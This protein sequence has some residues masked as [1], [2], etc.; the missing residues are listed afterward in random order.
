MKHI[1]L[2]FSLLLLSTFLWSQTLSISA[3]NPDGLYVCGSDQTTITIQN[4]NGQP[5]ATNLKVTVTFP[6]GVNYEAGTVTGAT[7]S[8]ISN[9]NAPVFALSDLAG[10][11]SASFTITVTGGCPLV[12]AINSGQTFANTILAN[13]NGGSKQTITSF[14]PI[15]TGLLNISSINPP[16]VNAQKGDVV[17][18]MITMKNTRQG[19]I[20]SLAFSDQHFPGISIDLQGGTNQSNL[21]TLFTAD[22]PGSVFTSIGDNDDLFEFGEELTLVEKVTI[23]DCG[24]PSITDQSLI[25]I[26][27]GC[28]G[29]VCRTD[30]I[31]AQIVILPTTQNP[32][33]SFIPVYGAPVSQCG[34]EP[35]TQEILI[36]N[37]GQLAAT[38]VNIN[39]FT[40]DTG[41]M[42]IDQG[43]FQVNS[44]SGWVPLVAD[45]SHATVLGSCSNDDYS[46]DVAVKVPEVPAGDTVRLRFNTYYCEPA[47]GALAPRMRVEY[48][49]FK[50]CPPNAPVGGIFNFYP[51]TT[52]LKIKASVDYKLEHCLQDD[53]I[54][55]LHYWVKSGRLMHDT[56]YLQVIFD[57]PWG[58]DWMQDCPF[59]LGGQSPLETHIDIDPNT[60]YTTVRMVFDLPILEDSVG[61]DLC[62]RYHCEQDL[63]C[64]S[65]IPNVPPRGMDYTVISPPSDCG[66]CQIKLYA[67]S[68][69]STEPD[70]AFNC[71]ITYCDQFILIVDNS[72]DTSGGGGGG[73][74]GLGGGLLLVDFKSYRTNYGF[75]DNN[76]DRHADNTNIAK[77][78]G[79]RRDRFL[80]GDTLRDELKAVMVSG[81]LSSLSFRVFF[82]SW[83]SDF[84]SLDGDMYEMLLGK[85]LFANYDTTSFAGAHLTIKTAGGQQYD[86]PI[87]LPQIRSDQHLIQVAEPNIRPPQ[88]RDALLNMFHQ[89]DLP[90]SQFP[91]LPPGFALSV[92][93]SLIFTSDFKFEYN[94]KP[95]GSNAPPLINFRNSICDIDKTLSWKLENF[96]TDKDLC[97]FSGYIESI[98]PEAQVINP[99]A[100][101]TELSPFQYNIRIARPNMFPFEVRQL[102]TVTKYGYSL[103]T[104]VDLLDTK[105]NFLRLQD[106]VSLF[107]TTLLNPG[108]GGDSLTLDLSSF[109]ADPLD[110]GYGFELST[111]FDTTCGYNGTQFGRTVLG[112]H[113]ANMCFHNPID[114]TYL[115]GNPNGYASGSPKLELPLVSNIYYLPTDEVDLQFLLHNTSALASNNTWLSIEADGPLAGLQLLELPAQTPV[116]QIGG[117]YQ[118][119]T[120]GSNDIRYFQLKATNLSC[121][122]VTLKIKFGWDCA[123]VFNANGDACGLFVKTIELRPQPPELELVILK[124]PQDIPL[125]EP[126]DYF[127]FEISNANDGSALNVRPTVKLPPGVRIQPGSSQLSYPAGGAYVNLPDPI[128]KIGNVWEFDPDAVSTLLAQDGLISADMAPLNTLRIRF[129]ILAECGAV[130]NAQ[131]IFGA[132]AVQAC[133]ISSNILRKPG[134]PLNIA[135][136]Q[137]S[138]SATPNLQFSNLPAATGCGVEVELTAT[139]A[140]N[141]NAA[142]GDS[143]YVLLPAGTS[144]VANSYIKGNNAPAG[145]PQI[146]GHQIQLPL[147]SNVGAG[148]ILEFKFKI[149]YDD[150]GDCSDKFL[151]LQT[152]E[153]TEAYCSSSNKLCDIYVATGEALLN[154]NAQN[155]ELKLTNFELNTQGGNTTF[156]AVLENAGTTVANNPLVQI[157]HDQNGNGQVDAGE[158]KVFETTLNGTL[159][160]GGVLPFNGALSGVANSALCDLIALIPGAQNC[161]CSDQVFPLGGQQT[162]TQG[163]GLCT[164]QSVNVG[165]D[166]TAGNTY[167]W[168][169]PNGLSCLNCAHA[170]YIPTPDVQP[171]E[172]VTLVLEEKAGDCTIEHKFEIQYGG[173]FG[174]ETPSQAICEGEPV[175]LEATS[176]GSAYQWSGPG[177]TNPNLPTQVVQPS[178]SAVYSVT[179][180]FGGGCTGT[181]TVAVNVNANFEKTLPTVTI[182][183]GETANI[184]GQTTG[185]AGVYRLELQQVNGCDSIITQELKV[186]PTNIQETAYFCQGFSVTVLDSV[187]TAPGSI[188]RTETASS[189][190]LVTTCYTVSAYANPEL[191]EQDSTIIISVNGSTVIETPN[192]FNTYEW[193]PPGDLSCS[194]CP[195]PIATNDTSTT[196]I[197]IVTDNHGCKDT[198]QYRIFVC[199]ENE[200]H[201]PNAFSPNGDSANDVFRVVPHEGAEVIIALRVYDRWGQKLY[202]G[203]G[204]NA[205]WDG[206]IGDKL[207]PSDT[208]VYILEYDCG[209]ERHVESG[210]VTLLR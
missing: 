204:K 114:K 103:P 106:N 102:S 158:P 111:R 178:S 144:Y 179:V 31:E 97:Q 83:M 4:G 47:C 196:F 75:Q 167:T 200:L 94:F 129:R 15:E 113:Y 127:E 165:A 126:S 140:M 35:S 12:A 166:S 163:I 36:V 187:F 79:V 135:G 99:C 56:G 170:I 197:L 150:P 27:W 164:L 152:R 104:S 65:D 138:Y 21:P 120:M 80:V 122:T 28:G 29:S 17:M 77:A 45:S 174:I 181:G 177:I 20:H 130:A 50:A 63:P 34:S 87:G 96:C 133:G 92:G 116:P 62:L 23:E 143:I 162:I 33:L 58:F 108:L 73:G 14:Y 147:P 53:S 189:G 39:P 168:L 151:I 40:I 10:G 85:K 88:I 16:T 101:S 6:N 180:T 93:D 46:V 142:P 202:E 18:R 48:N 123:P 117:V 52:L 57:I 195:D 203:S 153:K 210:D 186:Q 1:T 43:S 155:P 188:C 42:A 78:A 19:P 5:A 190:C 86:C 67:Y 110:E 183:E 69:F 171:G 13:Y 51:D 185:T 137:P 172:L 24:I 25:I 49:Y 54:Y 30:S 89:F 76:D 59:M 60:H 98:N 148:S 72:C 112:M 131:P 74:G 107:G 100:E 109:F 161:A 132:E 3:L 55:T 199:N 206:K 176:G 149:K 115:I 41:F 105:L 156:N 125:C 118:L 119:N 173:N 22:V 9:L 136:V 66:G 194:D 191:P 11:A 8:N 146:S 169:T 128:Q 160:A 184:L 7:E 61:S 159:A 32:N 70:Q 44:G 64:Q 134:K 139:I 201:I 192:D 82:E 175:T 91:C 154:M 193:T 95:P 208:Y 121:R 198:A 124:E 71:A 81:T 207:A 2:T 26:G 145:P 141:D 209:G 182:C 157:F 68:L 205:Q 38:G 84:D 37:T 90:F